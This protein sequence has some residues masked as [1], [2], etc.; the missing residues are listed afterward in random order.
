MYLPQML[1]LLDLAQ[2]LHQSLRVK[3][4]IYHGLLALKDLYRQAQVFLYLTAPAADLKSFTLDAQDHLLQKSSPD[5]A[6]G[7]AQ[8]VITTGERTILNAQTQAAPSHQVEEQEKGH[9]MTLPLLVEGRP[10]GAIQ[11]SLDAE[12][13]VFTG[14]D[15]TLLEKISTML[16]S[17]LANAKAFERQETFNQELEKE[18][19]STTDQLRKA[20]DELREAELAR[21][22]SIS[23][24]AHELR[25]PI[26]SIGGFATLFMKGKLG[27]LTDDQLEFSTIIKKNSSYIERMINDLLVLTKLEL[28]KLDLKFEPVSCANLITEALAS[29]K[30]SEPGQLDR[31]QL[32]QIQKA[33]MVKADKLRLLQVL[34]N[35]IS[36]A[37]KYAPDQTPVYINCYSKGEKVIFSIDDL[38]TP[39]TEDQRNRVFEKF[40]RIKSTSKKTGSGLGLAI[41]QKIIAKHQGHLWTTVNQRGGNSFLFSLDRFDLKI[42][43]HQT[44]GHGEENHIED[45]CQT[46]T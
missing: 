6:S 10:I 11:L 26:T 16:A 1:K 30:G 39:L 17:A 33:L 23:M 32:E 36:N 4:V 14:E 41:C 19:R 15:L 31:V 34:S 43:A 18:I 8:W 38:G 29:I 21:S 9:F 37:L 2:S 40:Y 25:T 45:C 27:P 42:L 35:L 3:K 44:P 46:T 12:T 5:T 7:L 28:D 24:V 13:P 22:E 20:N